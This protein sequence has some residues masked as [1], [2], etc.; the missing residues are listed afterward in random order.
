MMREGLSNRA[1]NLDAFAQGSYDAAN[2]LA[3]F[4]YEPGSEFKTWWSICDWQRQL[5]QPFVY[6][7]KL[8]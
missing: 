3:I 5:E 6:N 7:R 1:E 2:V 4:V 8:L